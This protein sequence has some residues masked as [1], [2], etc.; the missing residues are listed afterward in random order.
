MIPYLLIVVLFM[1][2]INSDRL[3]NRSTMIPSLE[4]ASSFQAV[5][6]MIAAVT[7]LSY[8]YATTATI[9][10]PSTTATRSVPA[11][12]TTTTTNDK[13]NDRLEHWKD[14]WSTGKTSWHKTTVHPSLQQYLDEKLLEGFPMGGVRILVPLCG[15]TVD[16]EH[17]ARK[18][19]VAEVVG[20]DGVRSAVE[21]FAKEHP[22]LDVQPT[23]SVRNG[24]FETWKGQSVA[25][26]T[27][28]F[29]NLDVKTAGGTFDAAW[30]R[31]AL[32]AIQPS[33][34]EQYVAKLGELLSKKNGRIL[35]STLVRPSGNLQAGP[36]FSVDEAEVRRLFEKQPW[37]DSVE[38]LDVH[39]ALSQEV[40]YKSIVA[41]FLMGNIMEHIFLITTK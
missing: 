35:L 34:R 14:R 8:F 39:S 11:T 10:Q 9:K 22:D 26:L 27:G 18:R 2:S 5:A 20:V 16:M 6:V 37:V 24:E 25:L 29:F 31:G 12:T 17:M 1:V 4:S 7:A 28:D 30:D 3:A 13:N 32:V 38:L 15:K 40:W 41:Y 33:L 23:N 36:P 21:A 19:K